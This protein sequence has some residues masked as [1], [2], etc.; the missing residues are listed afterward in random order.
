M[1]YACALTLLGAAI[2]G[3]L[4]GLKVTRGLG[5]RLRAGTTGGGGLRFGGRGNVSGLSA[6]ALLSK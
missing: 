2:A 3:G 4:P 5:A 6:T 1:L